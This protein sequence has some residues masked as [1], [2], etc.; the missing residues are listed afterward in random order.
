[1]QG[2]AAAYS[3]GVPLQAKCNKLP[4]RLGELVVQRWRRVARNQEQHLKAGG[5]LA[6]QISQGLKQK[7]ELT[8]IG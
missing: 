6:C 1:M 5:H 7:V 4:E 8:F 3:T 2:I